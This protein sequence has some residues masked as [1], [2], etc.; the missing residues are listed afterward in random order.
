LSDGKILEFGTSQGFDVFC[1]MPMMIPAADSVE[2]L[3]NFK[4]LLCERRN[5]HTVGSKQFPL[6][7]FVFAIPAPASNCFTAI[8]ALIISTFLNSF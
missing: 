5:P 4:R 2:S 1:S 3:A 6:A 7:G 8:A